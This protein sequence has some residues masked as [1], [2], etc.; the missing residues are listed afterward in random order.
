MTSLRLEPAANFRLDEILDHSRAQW[1][2]G[3]AEAYIEAMFDEVA[4]IANR[5]VVRHR[6]A[7]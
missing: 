7:P 4:A 2:D 3:Q 6:I 1:G 5:R